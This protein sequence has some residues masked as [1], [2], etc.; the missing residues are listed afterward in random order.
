VIR[1]GAGLFLL[2]LA[3]T[4]LVRGALLD[5][6]AIGP[7]R[8][9]LLILLAVYW[10]LAAGAVPG[11]VGGFVIGLVA[12][13]EV[14]RWLGLHAALLSVVGFTVGNASRHLIR[15]NV[16]LQFL[17]VGTAA[18]VVGAT[19]AIVVYGPGT[20]FGAGLAPLVGSALY[21][22]L[23]GPVLYMA[24][25]LVGLPDPLARVPSSE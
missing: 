22:A 11:T 16:M 20:L 4:L 13:V 14:G 25:R 18:L 10:A 9:D 23:L 15:E 7:V 5:L 19:R 2:W 6:F 3:S 24:G 8:P 21:T 12:D 17:L 1:A